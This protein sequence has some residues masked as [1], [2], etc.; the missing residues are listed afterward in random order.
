VNT[1]TELRRIEKIFA[2]MNSAE[3]ELGI[4]PKINLSLF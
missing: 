2:H 1:I 3:G 4:V